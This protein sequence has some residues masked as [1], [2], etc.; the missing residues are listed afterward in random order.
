MSSTNTPEQ[1][2]AAAEWVA[3]QIAEWRGNAVYT[4]SDIRHNVSRAAEIGRPLE[5][6]SPALLA[7]L[8]VLR[9]EAD[10]YGPSVE[11]D[12]RRLITTT[13]RYIVATYTLNGLVATEPWTDTP[14]PT[15][16]DPEIRKLLDEL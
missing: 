15:D 3:E 8:D 12:I 1:D 11:Q 7:S 2:K 5:L 10:D 16:E 14:P 4:C 13:R 9:D 6:R